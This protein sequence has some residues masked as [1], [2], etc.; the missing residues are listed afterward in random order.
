MKETILGIKISLESEQELIQSISEYINSGQKIRI[1]TPNPEMV[2]E[3]QRDNDFK[4]ILNSAEITIPD[5]KGLIWASKILNKRLKNT[6]P[7][8]DLM[9]KI[10]A[11]ASRKNWTIFLL[12]AS[13]GIADETKSIL[14]VRYPGIKIIGFLEGSPLDEDDLKTQ[15]N[16]L[17]IIGKR[18]ID[19]LFVAYGAPKQEKWIHRNISSLP[20]AVAMG[21]GGA[22]NYISGNI[23]RA[24]IWMRKIGLEWFYRLI[25]EPWRWKR[26]LKLIRFSYL[27]FINRIQS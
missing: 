25:T 5:G 3:A 4:L 15:N 13:K 11:E 6:I 8:T 2:I 17:K 21:A 18:K 26:Q 10:C 16:I 27:V 20:V 24:P 9:E 19:L 1:F 12:G 23:S 14:E 22:F 7:G